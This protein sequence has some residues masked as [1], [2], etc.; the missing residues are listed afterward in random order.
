MMSLQ[1]LS[2]Q[3]LAKRILQNALASG[4]VSHAYIFHGP[5]GT[6][7][8]Q[9]A[10]AFAKAILCREDGTDACGDCP[11]CRKF[12]SGNHAGLTVVEPDGASVK[13]GQIRNLQRQFVYRSVD[14]EAR[15]VYIV[16]DADRMTEQAAN[17][18]LKFLEEPSASLTAIL[19][20]DNLR[21]LLPTIRSRAQE[22]PFAPLPPEELEK[23]LLAEGVPGE[24]ARPAAH[25]AAGLEAARELA[26]A[27]WFAEL[28]NLMIQ[29]AKE[30]ASG[31]QAALVTAM[32]RLPGRSE[33]AG[34]ADAL[35][36]LF[37][38]WFKD[39]LHMQWNRREKVVFTDQIGTLAKET[40]K[41]S[42]DEWTALMDMAL[43]AKRRIRGHANVQ[44]TLDQFL[45]ALER[46]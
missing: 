28:R 30:S 1:S 33:L 15:Q 46:R 37:L 22:V 29:L 42:A 32:K 41:K 44:L 8:R 26:A 14:G 12:D 34:H 17:S 21:A 45:I 23:A 40:F 24:L 39:M 9:A 31:G 35:F 36:D 18:L 16:E 19:L 6:G 4:N 7:K 10:M 5:P 3:P 38:L 43:E 25:L 11:S 20:A 27:D 2:G 13:I